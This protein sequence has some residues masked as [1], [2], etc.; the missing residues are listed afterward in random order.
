MNK[1]KIIIETIVDGQL[2]EE[3]YICKIGNNNIEYNDKQKTKTVLRV[4]EDKVI[5]SRSGKMN[6]SLY[7]D[8]ESQVEAKLETT[9]EGQAFSMQLHIANKY[10]DIKKHDKILSIEIHFMREDENLV[11]Q[12]FKVEEK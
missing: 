10:L 6:Y 7:H 5:I 4:E 9:I 12:I 8:G 3:K 11:K 1:G 2:T